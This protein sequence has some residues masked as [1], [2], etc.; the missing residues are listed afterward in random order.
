MK[1]GSGQVLNRSEIRESKFNRAVQF[2]QRFHLEPELL[3]VVLVSEVAVENVTLALAGK[4]Y[5]A[6][7][8]PEL[9]KVNMADL[10]EFKHLERP[11]E[12]D[13][14]ALRELFKLME[15]NEGLAMSLAQGSTETQIA[16]VQQLQ[17]RV[18]EWI[19]RTLAARQ[20]LQGGLVLWD[21]PHPPHRKDEAARTARAAQGLPRGH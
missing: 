16:A 4:K 14:G 11:R 17:E 13:I 6:T 15:L 12:Y 9:A 19:S 7:A 5:D 3:A 20:A 8:L 18:K 1:K 10:T 2:D 21:I